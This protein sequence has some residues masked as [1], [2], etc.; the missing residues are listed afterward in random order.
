M[1]KV[2]LSLLF[3]GSFSAAFA[4]Q[5]PLPSDMVATESGHNNWLV[6]GDFGFGKQTNDN[7]AFG[8]KGE[9][10]NWSVNPGIGYKLN[11]HMFVGIQ[12]GISYSKTN[13][14]I[15]GSTISDNNTTDNWT[16]GLFLRHICCDMGKT[17][18]C[19]SQLNLSY[20]GMDAYPNIYYANSNY[21]TTSP[22]QV[23]NG[24]GFTGYWFPALGVHLPHAYALS[25]N[26]GGI[27]YTYIT[28]DHGNGTSSN[29]NVT[30]GQQIK[31][32]VQKEFSCHKH[33]STHA[34]H[35]PGDDMSGRKFEKMSGDDDE[36]P[37]K[38]APRR[39]HDM[40]DE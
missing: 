33:S 13:I 39:L 32:G 30:F 15:T 9:Y 29:V 27:G 5:P 2:F 12:G 20:I 23:T 4:Q 1:R 7:T 8:Q 25:L 6:Y 24:Y 36:A 3:A 18:Y 38:N 40:D 22:D 11:N 35:E 31:I 17:F 16:L 34:Y 10:T 19:Y 37:S 28:Q 21:N 14:S 26:L